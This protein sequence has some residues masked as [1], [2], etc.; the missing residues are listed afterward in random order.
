MWGG[1]GL[2]DD[3]KLSPVVWFPLYVADSEARV[4]LM[5]TFC[6]DNGLSSKGSVQYVHYIRYCIRWMWPVDIGLFV[7]SKISTMR[8]CVPTMA[9]QVKGSTGCTCWQDVA[10]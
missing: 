3:E 6:I 4:S 2:Y 8:I 10:C 5:A 1:G 9:S 7:F